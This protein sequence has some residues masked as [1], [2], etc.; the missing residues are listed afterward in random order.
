MGGAG[1]NVGVWH[2]HFTKAI[3][4]IYGIYGRPTLESNV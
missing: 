4:S 1:M 2:K 3:A